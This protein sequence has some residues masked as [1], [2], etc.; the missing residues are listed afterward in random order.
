MK[1][2]SGR[3][4]ADPREWSYVFRVNCPR[5]WRQHV[6]QWLR[7][8]AMRIDGRWS[9]GIEIVSD[10]LLPAGRRAAALNEGMKHARRLLVDECRSA[11]IERTLRVYQPHLYADEKRDG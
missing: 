4:A 7:L 6:A 10:P 1:P 8:L 3:V 11:A 9:A 2:D 5:G